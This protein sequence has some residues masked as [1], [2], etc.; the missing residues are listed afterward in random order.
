MERLPR[1]MR[2]D[3]PMRGTYL[4]SEAPFK[5]SWGK[6][7]TKQELGQYQ[8]PFQW[9]ENGVWRAHSFWAV[10]RIL[11]F[12][13]HC[14][15]CHDFLLPTLSVCSISI[16]NLMWYKLGTHW[17]Y[18]ILSVGCSSHFCKRLGN[19]LK[20][21]NSIDERRRNP[22]VPLYRAETQARAPKGEWYR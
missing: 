21:L 11:A 1:A 7:K 16:P 10:F 14:L 6:K 2:P 15:L 9:R 18:V 13:P 22:S 17:L 5:G 3:G 8:T 12:R 20:N 4:P 19:C